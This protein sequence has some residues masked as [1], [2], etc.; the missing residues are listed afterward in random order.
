M[1][2]FLLEIREQGN[3]VLEEIHASEHSANLSLLGFVQKEWD[4][5]LMGGPVDT[6]P[7]D[8]AVFLFFDNVDDFSYS[9]TPFNVKGKEVLPAPPQQD[10]FPGMEPV[11]LDELEARIISC[12]LKMVAPI[13]IKKYLHQYFYLDFALEHVKKAQATVI[14]K[15]E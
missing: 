15:M 2:V 11:P 10:P 9:I 12:C 13:T 14:D 7:A 8:D 6:V 3:S 1:P 5:D 4:S